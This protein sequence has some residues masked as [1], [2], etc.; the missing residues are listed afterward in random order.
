MAYP[1]PKAPNARIAAFL[2]ASRNA[3]NSRRREGPS[4]VTRGMAGTAVSTIGA[5]TTGA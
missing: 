5:G 4:F 2:V 3:L 1:I